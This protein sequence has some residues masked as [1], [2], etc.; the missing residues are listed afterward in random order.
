MERL[1]GNYYYLVL[2]KRKIESGTVDGMEEVLRF[3]SGRQVVNK[4]YKGLIY[5]FVVLVG[6]LI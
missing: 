1:N 2:S 3:C 5:S 4:Y 6:W